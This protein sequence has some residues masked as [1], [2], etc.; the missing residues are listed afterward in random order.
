[1]I[2]PESE[3][4]RFEAGA[5]DIVW[6]MSQRL[7]LKVCLRGQCPPLPQ[8]LTDLPWQHS[9]YGAMMGTGTFG[10][11]IL[12]RFPLKDSKVHL[13]WSTTITGQR[14]AVQTKVMV[15]RFADVRLV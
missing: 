5:G 11:A 13:L 8:S 7:K 15:N 3:T 6:Y 1:M 10:V 12:S 14:I 2:M 4:T 9:H